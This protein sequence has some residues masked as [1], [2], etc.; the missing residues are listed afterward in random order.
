MNLEE[1]IE[2]MQ[3]CIKELQGRFLVNCPN[4][5]CKVVDKNGT[6]KIDILGK[7]EEKKQ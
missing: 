1:G 3:K 4:F 6:K 5:I 7:K 2:L